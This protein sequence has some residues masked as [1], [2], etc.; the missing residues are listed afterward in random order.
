MLHE[1]AETEDGEEADGDSV[2]EVGLHA[3]AYV[4]RQ[5]P[6]THVVLGSA[7][8]TDAA[9]L[10]GDNVELLA[11]LSG[12]ARKVGKPEDLLQPEKQGGLGSLLVA[13]Q[14]GGRPVSGEW[15]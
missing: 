6:R 2:A 1:A 4:Y 10:R 12:P 14:W 8:A 7:N 3:K 13:L 15:P 5:G 11:E 9:L